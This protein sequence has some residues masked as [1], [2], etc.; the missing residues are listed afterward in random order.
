M[1]E[2]IIIDLEAKT[3][4][5]IDDIKKL[6]KEL[7]N[8]SKSSKDASDSL[9]NASSS[10]DSSSNS[11]KKLASSFEEVKDNGGAIAILDSLTGG[12]ASR[13][14]D[15]YEATKLFNFSLKGTKKAL[16]AS[17]VGALVVA[18]GTVIAYWD[19]I[20]KL[21]DGANRKLKYQEEN[22][23][24]QLKTQ[25]LQLD[26]LKQ[27]IAIEELRNGF[28]PKLTAEYKKQLLIQRE[29]NIAL[30]ENLQTQLDIEESKNKEVTL[31]E[32]IKIAAS[33]Q[34]GIGLQAEQIAKAT[35]GT[36]KKSIEI[37]EKLNEAKKLTG[38]IDLELAQIDKDAVDRKKGD[39]DKT[40]EREK[41]N[42]DDL[43]KIRKALIDTEDKRRKEQLREIKADY[44]EKIKLAEKYYGEESEE[45]LALREAQKNAIDSQQEKFDNEDEGKRKAKQDKE[46]EK[47][48]AL[49]DLKNQIKDAEAVTEEERRLL[50]IEKTTEHYNKLIELAKQKGLSTVALEEAKTK[51]LNKLNQTTSKNEIQW[52][53]LTQQE[54]SQVITQGLNN[55]TSILGEESAAGKAAAIA[56]A[57]ISTY[58]SATDSYK[59]LSGIPIIGPALGFA[60]A[61]AAIAS[62]VANVKKIASTK[63]PKG[64]G[65][66]GS[67]PS[68]SGGGGSAPSVSQPPAFNVVGASS[69]NQ[70]ADAIGS[71]TKEPVKAY[72]VS[73]DVT[74]AQSMDRNIVDGASI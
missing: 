6:N 34:L 65:G 20:T 66:G 39:V 63:T 70:L 14:R 74:T 7:N 10:L 11:A 5:A 12:L 3:D 40:K 24:K 73:N 30:L 35:N 61:G 68:V 67:A 45:V 56:S 28:S 50:E 4:K 2:K 44:D 60:A 47:A 1:A 58:Q 13:V 62:G 53:K 57:T 17:G 23:K 43:E 52:E 49:L 37:Q 36:S 55:L 41:Q 46:N 42:S 19:D 32:K 71:Q 9:N 15:A 72:V 26:L 33:G 29:Q 54:K 64:R 48:K 69:T 59:S 27:Q 51:A 8:T 16:I 21:I 38:V 22:L 18:L 25:T 31:W